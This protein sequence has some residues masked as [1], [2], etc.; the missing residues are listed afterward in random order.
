MD[1]YIQLQFG[2]LKEEDSEEEPGETAEEMTLS[3]WE[4]VAERWLDIGID[5]PEGWTAVDF[6]PA[7]QPETGTVTFDVSGDTTPEAFAET[8]F[9]ITRNA[10]VK[11]P[12]KFT[13]I[14]DDVI[15]K[16]EDAKLS[17]ANDEKSA[18]WYYAL[19]D[20]WTGILCIKFTY[21]DTTCSWYI[22]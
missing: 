7:L 2:V 16:F 10:S 15:D 6:D 18:G 13:M 3:N 12:Y 8:I 4:E 11:P 19:S 1:D 17:T 5:V 14:E 21:T 9:R 22:A 20:S